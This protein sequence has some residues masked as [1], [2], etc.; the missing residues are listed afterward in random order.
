MII[1]DDE[2]RELRGSCFKYVFWVLQS[3]KNA[4]YLYT[5]FHQA[6]ITQD[7]FALA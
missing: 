4:I 2:I 1:F 5:V 7:M 6:N 3:N